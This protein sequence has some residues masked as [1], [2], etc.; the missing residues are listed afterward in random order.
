MLG[1]SVRLAASSAPSMPFFC[2]SVTSFR[3]AETACDVSVAMNAYKSYGITAA[4]ANEVLH[5]VDTAVSGWRKEADRLGIPKA[6][7]A[8][9]TEAFE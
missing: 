6:E 5:A 1:M 8:L 4:Q 7:Q 9:M 2:A 3:T